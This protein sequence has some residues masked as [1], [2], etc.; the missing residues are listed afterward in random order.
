M[1]RAI[2]VLGIGLM[3]AGLLVDNWLRS[4]N[5]RAARTSD[6]TRTSRLPVVLVWIGAVLLVLSSL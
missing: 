6:K 3:A 5:R 2:Q 4:R 1:R